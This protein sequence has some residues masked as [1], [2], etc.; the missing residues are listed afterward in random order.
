MFKRGNTQILHSY[1]YLGD[2]CMLLSSGQAC[3]Y[4]MKGTHA[5][6]GGF[7]YSSAY[8][9]SVPPGL[10]SLEQY[11]L[12]SQLGLSDDGGEYW[13]TRRTTEYAAIEYRPGSDGEKSRPV[14]VS[15]WRP[16]PDVKIKTILVPPAEETPNWH[17]R[18][19]KIEAGR[20]VMTADGAFAIRNVN[21]ENGRYLEPYDANKY[22]GTSPRILGNYD[23]TTPAG[24]ASGKD[25]AFAAAPPA[26]AVGIRALEGWA[27]RRANLVNADPNSNLVESRTV[28][29]TLQHTIRA[30]ETATYVT[31]VYAKP[32]GPKE[33]A[34]SGWDAPPIV[35]SW[36]ENDLA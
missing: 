28:I 15:V 25:G 18:A 22:E 2:H 16:F 7:A 17:L 32:K 1:S 36:L 3:S 10:F 27:G 6:Y 14:L 33:E 8:A 20:E 31:A 24:W 9:Y 35:P 26:G 5:K 19:H 29:P 21:T 4:P 12:A 11:A 34:L 13:K 30:G 23:V